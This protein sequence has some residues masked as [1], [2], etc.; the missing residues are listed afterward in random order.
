MLLRSIEGNTEVNT[1]ETIITAIIYLASIVIFIIVIALAIDHYIDKRDA[2]TNER[3]IEWVRNNRVNPYSDDTTYTP[4][5]A[6]SRGN[7]GA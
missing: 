6:V 2:L 3:T 7:D 4:F 5:T 1:Y